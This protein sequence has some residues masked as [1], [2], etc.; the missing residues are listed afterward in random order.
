MGRYRVIQWGVGYTGA[1]ALR[2]VVQ[3]PALELVGI[4]CHTEEKVGKS[5]NE[6]C[7]YGASDGITATRDRGQLLTANADCVLFMP[8]DLFD[9]PSVLGGPSELWMADLIAILESG[10]NVISPLTCG[11][12]TRQMAN[13]HSFLDRINS[14]C[15]K[16][17]STV[18]F[19]GF[20][21]G[22]TTDYLAFVLASAVGET[23]QIRT[24]EFLEY[25][26]YPVAATLNAV[27]LGVSAEQS[28]QVAQT[29]T[30]IWSSGLH[31]LGEAMG[32][33]IDDVKLDIDAY[34]ASEDFTTP[35]GMT[36]L[37]GQTS[38]LW[39]KLRGI[40]A[41][42]ERFVINHVSRIAADAAPDWPNIGTDGGYRVEIESY[43][44]VLVDWPMGLPGG[45]GTSFADAMIMTAARCVNSIE[46][47]VNATPGYKSFLD[48]APIGGK[49]S[50]IN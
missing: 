29:V 30:A 31:L 49:Y 27:G 12:S 23:E 44:P 47:V 5:S 21:P 6:I 45:G 48:L 16:G 36:V 41:G 43:P 9:D 11:I 15:Q 46:A 18:T 2:Y 3:N 50:L 33:S 22:F 7:G 32:V 10:A 14:A 35:G 17:G 20:D 40:C 25:S 19:T 24:W 42:R 28:T 39:W 8:R 4:Q 26:S 38:A 1:S 13:P 37:A 34:F